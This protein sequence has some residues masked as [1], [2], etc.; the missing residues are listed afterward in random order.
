M[1]KLSCLKFLFSDDES[2]STYM[3]GEEVLFEDIKRHL[4]L[5]MRHTNVAM[6][7]HHYHLIIEKD[8]ESIY[9]T[10]SILITGIELMV[11]SFLYQKNNIVYIKTNKFNLWQD[12]ITYIPPLFLVSAFINW[13]FQLNTFTSS[14][15][16][17][18]YQT[19]IKPNTQFTSIPNPLIEGLEN[20]RKEYNGF[21]DLHMHLSGSTETDIVWQEFLRSPDKI[22]RDLEAAA[23]NGVVLEQLKQ[24]S[25]QLVP[26]K[27][28]RLL[29]IA[30]MLRSVLYEFIFPTNPSKVTANS[31]KELLGEILFSN[32]N[33]K[34]N[35]GYV[36]PFKYLLGIDRL[37]FTQ[38]VGVE[39]LM[40]VLVLNKIKKERKSALANIFHFYLLI[41]GLANRLMVHQTHQ[42]GFG[43]FQK[44]TINKL[45]EKSEFFFKERFFQMNGNKINHISFLEGRFSPQITKEK[46]EYLLSRINKGWWHLEKYLISEGKP[47]HTIAKLRLVAHFIKDKDRYPDSFIRYKRFRIDLL[48]RLNILIH[49][50]KNRRYYS[51]IVAIDAAANELDTPPEVFG[52]IFRKARRCDFINRCTYHVG[53]DFFHVLSGIRA[54]Y[55][56]IEFINLGKKDRIGHATALGISPGLWGQSV[57]EKMFIRSGEHLDNLIFVRNLILKGVILYSPNALVKIEEEAGILGVNIFGGLFDLDHYTESWL[58]RKFCPMHLFSKDI[59]EASRLDVF[60]I[61]E[62]FDIQNSTISQ[63]SKNLLKQYHDLITK[64]AYDKIIEIGPFDILTLEDILILQLAILEILHDK[65]IAIETLPTSNLRISHYKNFAEYH[66]WQWK[67]WERKHKKIPA[68][69]VGSDDTGVFATNIFNEYAHI[70]CHLL[71]LNINSTKIDQFIDKLCEESKIF[72]FE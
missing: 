36:H 68:I 13:K 27:F 4:F 3:N 42:H 37:D 40:Y 48:N 23:A 31:F 14:N 56:A 71:S 19:Y 18:Y 47:L 54:I 12:L 66:L 17:H 10:E 49:L 1:E 24:E 26:L 8:F 51:N 38:D 32:A 7:D 46:N 44:N 50:V 61:D 43:Q 22:Y 6:P 52:P 70:Y 34:W 9:N 11:E 57:G 60:D 5:M 55:E 59:H 2:L 65:E 30:K 15:L 45:R 69:V 64:P 29:E 63:H 35:E 21:H 62:W 58:L 72:R 53:E 33:A 25:H 28:L 67:K 41:L 20:K 39:S 16:I